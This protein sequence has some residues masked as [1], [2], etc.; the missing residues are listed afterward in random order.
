MLDVFSTENLSTHHKILLGL[1]DQF[2]LHNLLYFFYE[3]KTCIL[4]LVFLLML[5]GESWSNSYFED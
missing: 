5:F 1:K 3:N 4:R 2:D